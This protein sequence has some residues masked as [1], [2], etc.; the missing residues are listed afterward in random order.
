MNKA[1]YTVALLLFVV[2][3]FGQV[4]ADIKIG[5]CSAADGDY[6][7]HCN[8][9]CSSRGYKGGHCGSIFNRECWC[10]Q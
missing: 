2:M 1:L 9:T 8:E 4:K 7:E 3:M 5:S 10:D 6:I